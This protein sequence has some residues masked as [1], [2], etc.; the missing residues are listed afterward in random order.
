MYEIQFSIITY[1][2]QSRPS[3]KFFDESK[4]CISV[5]DTAIA[6][7][8]DKNFN[9]ARVPHFFTPMIIACGRV[10]EELVTSEEDIIV[11]KRQIIV[12]T[13]II[14]LCQLKQTRQHLTDIRITR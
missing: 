1:R 11:D 9:S 5:D 6:G 8:M 12:S 7:C 13:K 10:L 4:K 3:G 14:P 2:Y